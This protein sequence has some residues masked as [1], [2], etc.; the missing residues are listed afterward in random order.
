MKVFLSHTDD[1]FPRYFGDRA[2]AALRR[3][4]EVVRHRGDAVL[5]GAAL[6][7]AAAGCQAIIAH[8]ATPGT[9][10]LFAAAPD[11]RAFL[12]C[13]VDVSTVDIAAA[14]A[15]GILVTHATPGFTDAVAELALGQMLDLARGISDAVVAQRRGEAATPRQ[16]RQLRG[17]VLGLVGYGRIARR[18]AVL[19][20]ALGMTV[21]AHD[22]HAAP[23]PEAEPVSLPGLL[24]RADFVVLLALSTPGTAGMMDAAAFAAMRPGGFFLN[25]SRGELVDEAALEAALDARHL[26]GAALDVGSA[27]DQMPSPRL[28]RR[29]DVIATPHVGG[30]TV[31]ATEH[32]A[33]DTVRQVE[34][35]AAGRM[36][37]GALNAE[38]AFRLR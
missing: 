14:S 20:G 8:R 25:L 33:M 31:E 13:A 28:A 30:L 34:A 18:L 6:A 2:L 11:L 1:A 3:H 32:Q 22:P 19:A 21:L 4:A 37:E 29:A 35:L 12:R 17:A 27:P 10:E 5:S 36:P 38:A 15:Q 24:A 23:G 7:E 16:G 26:S 9:A